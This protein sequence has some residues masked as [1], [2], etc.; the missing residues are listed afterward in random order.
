MLG[1]WNCEKPAGGFHMEI[2]TGNLL[3]MGLR[4][5]IL[6][7][8]G[9]M[10]S[11]SSIFYHLLLPL[12]IYPVSWL[13]SFSYESVVMTEMLLVNDLAIEIIPA[14][15]AVSAYFL[16]LILNLATPMSAKKRAGSL[17]FSFF[18]LLLLNIIRISLLS[19]MLINKSAS[20]DIVHMVLWYSLSIVFVVGIWFLSVWVFKIRQVPVY[21]DIKYLK[22]FLEL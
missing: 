4:Y 6:V 11:F 16:L 1:C 8:V 21:S 5:L 14:C 13:L 22:G 15:V 10:T 18:L 19:V 2:R 20:F 12:T 9:L 17:I 3:N 7:I